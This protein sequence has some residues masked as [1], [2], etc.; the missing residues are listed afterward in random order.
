MEVHM[1]IFNTQNN[2]YISHRGFTPLAPENSLPSFYYAGLLGQWAIETDVHIMKLL[3]MK[4]LGLDYFPTNRM[5]DL[6]GKGSTF[7][8]NVFKELSVNDNR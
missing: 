4:K 7:R 6:I 3:H 1:K 5:H 8:E 2:R